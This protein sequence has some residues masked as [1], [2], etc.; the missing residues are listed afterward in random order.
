MLANYASLRAGE[1]W[2]G[3][4][5]VFASL[6]GGEI[7]GL[8]GQLLPASVAVRLLA[9]VASVASLGGC[10]IVGLGGQFLLPASVAV[11]LLASVASCC[12]PQWL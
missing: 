7:V 4:L 10:E 6:G 9:S 2:P 12:Q 11:R 3:W 8:G 5:C 1:L